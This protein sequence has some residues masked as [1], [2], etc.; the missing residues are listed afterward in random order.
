MNCLVTRAAEVCDSERGGDIGFLGSLGKNPIAIQCWS[1][2]LKHTE[3]MVEAYREEYSPPTQD[4]WSLGYTSVSGAEEICIGGQRL[5][6]IS[7]PVRILN[8]MK[9]GRGHTD[10]HM[11]LLHVSTHSLIVGDH[12]VGNR[13]NRESSILEAIENGAKT[14]FDIIAYTYADVDRSLWIPA[15]SNVRLHVD[16]L[17]QQDKLPKE[18][19]VQKFQRTC[20]LRFLSRWTLAC[21]RSGF[22]LKHPKLRTAILLGAVLIAGFAVWYSVRS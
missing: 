5:R 3:M 8:S 13:R 14:L 15:A 10:G 22:Q 21:L 20:G 18:F 4:D 6:I 11:A 16:H 19:S 12:C 9:V 2:H 1:P 17:A 7:A